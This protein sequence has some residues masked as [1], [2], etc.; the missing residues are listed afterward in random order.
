[1]ILF[2]PAPCS[3]HWSWQFESEY[4]V[5][6]TRGE[7]HCDANHRD[8]PEPLCL[9]SRLAGVMM[10]PSWDADATMNN[11]GLWVSSVSVTL[12]QGDQEWQMQNS[13]WQW[14]MEHGKNLF[15]Y[16]NVWGSGEWWWHLLNV[17]QG[18]LKRILTS[19]ALMR[20]L[21][22][23]WEFNICSVVKRDKIEW[24]A[25]GL[26]PSKMQANLHQA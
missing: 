17:L 20:I 7:W 3:S 11:Y 10:S 15:C 6:Q 19:I 18:L 2:V 13:P 12:G 5:N 24:L 22:L 26:T 9:V 8:S 25:R 21:F 4:Y 14:E 1:M 16:C 23:Q